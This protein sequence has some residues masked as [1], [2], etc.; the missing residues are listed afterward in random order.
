MSEA[1]DNITK[2]YNEL[3]RYTQ[4]IKKAIKN[5]DFESILN[6][7]IS[8][9]CQHFIYLGDR[10]IRRQGYFPEKSKYVLFKKTF[11]DNMGNLFKVLPELMSLYDELFPIVDRRYLKILGRNP[12]N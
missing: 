1:G 8:A 6:L 7:E 5:G 3:N 4:K 12:K 9:W 2:K 10:V 11:D